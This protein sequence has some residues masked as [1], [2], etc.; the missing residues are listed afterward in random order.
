[1]SNIL[2]TGGAG[3]I[4]SHSVL[5]FH[6][7][8]HN[9]IVIDDLRYGTS[10]AVLPGKLIVGSI[11]DPTLIRSVIR[12]EQIDTVLHTAASTCITESFS[13]PLLY[14]ANNTC[15]TLNLV[16]ACRDCGVRNFILSSTAA[17]YG[18]SCNFR[19]YER[20]HTI[21][22][23]PYGRSKL[24]AETIVRDFSSESQL[25]FGILRYFNVGGADI[26]GRLGRLNSQSL[27]L[28]NHATRA[29]IDKS[30]ILRVYGVDYETPDR[31][32]VRDYVHV[33]DVAEAHLALLSY[34][35]SGG[36]S[37]IFNCGSGIGSSVF[38]VID[39]FERHS[40][41]R[42][43]VLHCERNAGDAPVV[44]SDISKITSYLKWTPI[45]STLDDIVKS[46]L[47]WAHIRCKDLP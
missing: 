46:E 27:Q 2:V 21:P 6:S 45:H 43:A 31:S 41:S 24:M 16:S 13:N 25:R 18:S 9:V 5:R 4:G 38:Q 29:T 47:K 11:S 19:C 44:V 42:I 30:K 3:Y 23:N 33:I 26:E 37:A 22:N 12:S 32:A 34:L 8:G 20:A 39:A 15:G 28:M 10:N 36:E 35:E 14:Y 7:A 40:N 1:M 17:V